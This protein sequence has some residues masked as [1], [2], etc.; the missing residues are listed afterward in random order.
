MKSC[1]KYLKTDKNSN[2]EEKW[3]KISKKYAKMRTL[4]KT[5]KKAEFESS[6][7]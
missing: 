5:I 2:K 3:L 6:Q 4:L 7:K 1:Q